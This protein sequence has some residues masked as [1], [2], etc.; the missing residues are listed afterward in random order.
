MS[1]EMLDKEAKEHNFIIREFKKNQEDAQLLARCFNSFDDPE[2]WPG[3]FSHNE[4]Y[5]AERILEGLEK[6][7]PISKLVAVCDSKIVGHC[8]VVEHFV[9]EDTVY[10]GLL[11]VDPQYQ[12][13]KIGKNLL[14]HATNKAIELQ[15][16]EITLHTWGG[17]LKA[18]PL[19]K[20]TGYFWAPDSSVYMENFLPA[21]LRRNLFR[22]YFD[23]F[24]WYTTF[25]RD[26][27]L[28]ADEQKIALMDI[29]NYKFEA[30]DNNSLEIIIDQRAKKISGFELKTPDGIVG[31]KCFVND[32]IGYPGYGYNEID[33]YFMN[34]TQEEIQFTLSINSLKGL[35]IEDKPDL[36]I[37]VP[38]GESKTLTAK[39]RFEENIPTKTDPKE[40]HERTKYRIESQINFKDKSIDL[41]VGLIPVNPL[42]IEIFPSLR[43][44]LPGEE[45]IIPIRMWNRT[46]E[47]IKGTLILNELE[48]VLIKLN[49]IP[50]T[51]NSNERK[52]INLE[53][54]IDDQI[55][56]SIIPLKL[57]VYIEKKDD[58]IKLPEEQISIPVIRSINSKLAISGYLKEN[59]IAVLENS[60]LRFVFNLIPSYELS[61]IVDKKDNSQY[62]IGNGFLDLG[63]PYQGWASELTRSKQ[64]VEL[65]QEQNQISLL[66]KIDSN[67]KKGISIQRKYTLYP[68][69]ELIE[70]SL[71]ITNNSNQKYKDIAL[72]NFHDN[73]NWHF[74]EGKFYLPLKAGLLVSH[75]DLNFNSI[76]H[77]P[78]DFNQWAESW[79]CIEFD[80]KKIFGAIWN[81]DYL[82]NVEVSPV[83]GPNFSFYFGDLEIGI[84]KEIKYYLYLGRGNYKEFRRLWKEI[85]PKD[86]S[87]KYTSKQKEM[88]I[89]KPITVNTE[90]TIFGAKNNFDIQP[91][92]YNDTLKIK[93]ENNT[94]RNF[95]GKFVFTLPK[96]ITFENGIHQFEEEI[97]NFTLGKP[98]EKVFKITAQDIAQGRIY[99]IEIKLITE[100]TEIDLSS[101][102]HILDKETKI[103]IEKKTHEN[104]NEYFEVS[105]GKICFAASKD[106]QGSVY[107]FKMPTVLDKNN[108]LSS[109]PIIKPF[110]WESHWFGGIG[111]FI[112]NLYGWGQ[113]THLEKFTSEEVS[114]GFEKGVKF[115]SKLQSKDPYKGL[116]LELEFTTLPQSN[117]LRS[118][119]RIVNE[120]EATLRFRGGLYA[121]IAVAEKVT[122]EFFTEYSG[123]LTKRTFHSRAWMNKS[124]HKWV[125]F[126][127]EESKTGLAVVGPSENS[128]K[129]ELE[130]NGELFNTV[131][132]IS[133]SLI[134]PKDFL[135][136]EMLFILY[137]FN[138]YLMDLLRQFGK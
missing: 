93:I 103:I 52:N 25:K 138:H 62:R 107:S 86:S 134:P 60:N 74:E 56:Q 69:S 34:Q 10:V 57:N 2:S 54:K 9:E 120:T 65:L 23:K 119:M 97:E 132:S 105:N 47:K 12:G 71:K 28:V 122:N 64:Q 36:M 45:T 37:I 99:P 43:S 67:I 35:V 73:F 128:L 22:G 127:D 90:S 77:F 3:G 70:I 84:S 131:N 29:Y 109:W 26:L 19:Y 78:K 7:T 92:N 24:D 135:E 51:L 129:M 81:I 88:P 33:W 112:R 85:I 118:V 5:T 21:I 42:E 63:K 58:V 50:I 108:L 59:K 41:S 137:P 13:M 39:A 61:Y 68:N 31:V 96:G 125:V 124:K 14:I 20:K 6:E 100:G 8:D 110:S 98:F 79:Y 4:P 101:L 104:G 80:E 115:T 87:V 83:M 76:R 111:P 133:N 44:I 94:L 130:D 117:M 17:N 102:V 89:I 40:V 116:K 75:D 18:V 53:L 113:I 48:N 32:N 95:K 49:K 27:S 121:F 66:F 30:D 91:L 106:M 11:G 46:S 72:R 1:K 123:K 82:K 55:S 136:H 16:D 38:A 126:N 15:K 114:Y